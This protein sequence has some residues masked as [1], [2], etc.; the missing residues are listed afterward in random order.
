MSARK[1]KVDKKLSLTKNKV[2]HSIIALA[3]ATV[4]VLTISMTAYGSIEEVN[5]SIDNV[6][7][8]ITDINTAIEDC[9]NSKSLAHDMAENARA[10]NLAE[11]N[12]VIVEAQK[13]W[14]NAEA[15]HKRLLAELDT[16]QV[17]LN[18]LT[19]QR[20]ELLAEQARLEEEAR[21]AEEQARQAA[22]NSKGRYIGEFNLTGYCNC[23]VCCGSY[24]GG[25]TASGVMP[26]AGVTIAVDRRV[27]PMGTKVYIEGLGYRIAQDTGGAIKG[28]KI[29]VYAESHSACYRPEYNLKG[30][31]V[32]IVE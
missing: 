27:I 2:L 11:D 13:I 30:A 7:N 10:L 19:Q 25:P 1:R 29:D 22:E 16:K 14:G 18:T 17:E 21:I 28:N 8:S 6:N 26:Q 23:S 24:A 31:K 5:S 9:I 20:D 3:S 15:E 32:Y 12:V 4:A